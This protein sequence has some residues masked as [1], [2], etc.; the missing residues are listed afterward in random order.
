MDK[1]PNIVFILSDDQGAWAM[2]CAGN[3]EIRTPNL[4]KLAKKGI[5]FENFFCTSPV[6]SP[7][8]ASILTGCIPSAHGVHDWIRSGNVSVGSLSQEVL[9]SG[10]FKDERKPIQYLADQATYTEVLAQNGYMCGLSGKW[11]LGDSITPQKGFSHWFTIARGGCKYYWPD[12]V[13]DGKVVIENNYLTNLITEDALQFL[14]RQKDSNV[15]FYLSV[16]YTAP[17]SPWGREHHPAHIYDS[18]ADCAFKSVPDEPIHPWQ[19]ATCPRG[20]GEERK[21]LLQGY[22]A[23]VTAMDIGIG[24]IIDKLDEMCIRENTLIVFMSDNGMNMGHHGIWGKGNGTF[25]LNMYDTS[26]K[27]PAIISRPGSVPENVVNYDLLS[28][29]D[30][31]PTFLDYLDYTFPVKEKLPGISFAPLL[32]GECF[33]ERENVVVFDEY[34]P[35]RMVR[36]KEWKYIHRYPYGPNELYNLVEDPDERVNLINEEGK[37]QRI[38]ELKGILDAWFYKY[39]NPK[40]D[41]AKEAVTGFGQLNIAGYKGLG[42][43]AF[44]PSLFAD[45][46]MPE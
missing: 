30:I 36:T 25:P 45:N 6:C 8:R 2:G 46:K 20:S 41:G 1:K 40:F 31:M 35:V 4:D 15:P 24:M 13:R 33:K 43:R 22:Y 37:Y 42:E 12:I 9:D 7:A 21:A 38:K 5:R 39:S 34:G 3:E 17:H 18:Y 29:Y 11:H 10:L 23:A 27:V 32:R 19:I 44:Y 14:D 28:Q 16:H 26:V